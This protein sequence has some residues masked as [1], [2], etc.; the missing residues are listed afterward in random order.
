MIILE[1]MIM[2]HHNICG[3]KLGLV[4]FDKHD[5]VQ[6]GQQ[7]SGKNKRRNLPLD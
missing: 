4:R 3:D 2:L 6:H 5:V 1:Y 7:L